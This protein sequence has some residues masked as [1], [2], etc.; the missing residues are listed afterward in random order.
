MNF[1]VP[2]AAEVDIAVAGAIYIMNNTIVI[3][4]YVSCL[5][6]CFQYKLWTTCE[7]VQDYIACLLAQF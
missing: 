2:T 3:R 6:S 5:T 1:L 7:E 4:L